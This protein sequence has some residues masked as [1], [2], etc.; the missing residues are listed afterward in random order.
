MPKGIYIAGIS[1]RDRKRTVDQMDYPDEMP[2]EQIAEM[3]KDS[4][5][6]LLELLKHF[7]WHNSDYSI[8]LDVEFGE[9]RDGY[10]YQDPAKVN[11][12]LREIIDT[13]PELTQWVLIRGK[14]HIRHVSVCST[15]VRANELKGIIARSSRLEPMLDRDKGHYSK[16]EVLDS[17][18]EVSK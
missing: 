18:K 6:R 16:K 14:A 15:T 9:G 5:I 11:D 17:A 3:E 4:P 7:P 13:L 1:K 12:G 8:W 2:E 10:V